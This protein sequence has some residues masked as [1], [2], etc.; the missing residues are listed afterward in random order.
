MHVQH[1]QQISA[2]SA[3]TMQSSRPDA[4]VVH[5]HF[6]LKAQDHLSTAQ[7]LHHSTAVSQGIH[8]AFCP[9]RFQCTTGKNHA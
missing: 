4:A 2:K 6:N 1:T 7:A 9:M 3:E 8:A 5:G